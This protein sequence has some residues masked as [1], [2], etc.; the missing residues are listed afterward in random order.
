M[1]ELHRDKSGRVFRVVTRME[2]EFS[3]TD[4]EMLLA[5]KRRESLKLPHGQPFDEATDPRADPNYYGEGAFRYE[6]G[7]EVDQAQAAIDRAR[8][9][10]KAQ[11]PDVDLS[12]YVFWPTR[13]DYGKAAVVRRRDFD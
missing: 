3:D 11:N 8:A 12:A 2:S 9:K 5:Y 7:Y 10:L 1:T 6:V 4:R 13:K